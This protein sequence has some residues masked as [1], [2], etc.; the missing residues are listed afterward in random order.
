MDKTKFLVNPGKPITL[1]AIGEMLPDV[2]DFEQRS[3]NAIN[4]AL[5]AKRPLLLRGEPGVGKS[6]LARAAAHVLG[7]AFIPF[8][9][10]SRTESRDL[11]W[12]FDAVQR[13]ADAQICGQMF[14]SFDEARKELTEEKYVRPGPLWWAFHWEG[15]E[16][17]SNGSKVGHHR[18][19]N[20]NSKTDGCVLL[21]DEIDKGER[22]VPNGL[23]EALG[24]HEISV[25]WGEPVV[26]RNAPP[27][28]IITSNSERQLP[29][30][31]IRRCLVLSLSLPAKREELIKKLIERGNAHFPN[32]NAAVLEAIANQLADDRTQAQAEHSTPLPGQAEYLDL[33]RAVTEMK[34]DSVEEQLK[35]LME[36]KD[37]VLKKRAGLD[38]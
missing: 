38:G 17:R 20:W 12:H 15:A 29:D 27:L 34:P 10:D 8:V 6:Q 37:F 16:K 4:T 5:A 11:L 7:R 18:L 23:L 3:V 2:H 30:A 9:V 24:S 14:K 28:V 26:V 1:P 35:V 31:F 32:A 21:I 33:L 13:L 25:P 19:E 36:I 22:D